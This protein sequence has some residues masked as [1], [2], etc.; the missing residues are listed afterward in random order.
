MFEQPARLSFTPSFSCLEGLLFPFVYN[1]LLCDLVE[2]G[3]LKVVERALR[4][5]E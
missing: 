2:A 1:Y 4:L 5:N 3:T